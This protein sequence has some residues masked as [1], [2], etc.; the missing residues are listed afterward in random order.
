MWKTLWVL[1]EIGVC[2][3]GKYG[4]FVNDYM[5]GIYLGGNDLWKS[6]WERGGLVGFS[7]VVLGMESCVDGLGVIIYPRWCMGREGLEVIKGK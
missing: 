5:N 2:L 7:W 4:F 1:W 6:V 3:G